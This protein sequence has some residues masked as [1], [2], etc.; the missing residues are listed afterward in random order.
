MLILIQIKS[1]DAFLYSS[2][3]KDAL[4]EKSFE[5]IDYFFYLVQQ[6]NDI[7]DDLYDM[8]DDYEENQPNFWLISQHFTKNSEEGR[9]LLNERMDFYASEVAKIPMDEKIAPVKEITTIFKDLGNKFYDDLA[10]KE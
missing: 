10:K 4:G 2:L 1:S 9:L 6:V 3:V 5:G 7:V 8:K